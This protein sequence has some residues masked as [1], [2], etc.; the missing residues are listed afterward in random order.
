MGWDTNSRQGS[1]SRS[2]RN[3]YDRSVAGMER[4]RGPDAK[5]EPKATPSPRI[6]PPAPDSEEAPRA[7]AGSREEDAEKSGEDSGPAIGRQP[8]QVALGEDSDSKR[9]KGS[10]GWRTGKEDTRAK[11]KEEKTDEERKVEAEL[12]SILK[13][14]PSMSRPKASG[15][16]SLTNDAQLS[17][18][19]NL[20]VRTAIKRRKPLLS[21]ASH[22]HLS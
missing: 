9:V 4:N 1:T 7:K 5:A 13:R 19:P 22:L 15:Q 3:F 17:Y 10:D 6:P 21:I 20:T 11:V 16:R 14:S 12:N 18:S 2:D 8:P